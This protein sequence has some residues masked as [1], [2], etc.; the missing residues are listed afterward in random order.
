MTPEDVANAHEMTCALQEILDRYTPASTRFVSFDQGRGGSVSVFC[1]LQDGEVTHHVEV[2]ADTPIV[3]FYYYIGTT[4]VG[5]SLP[6]IPAALPP[7]YLYEK[8]LETALLCGATRIVIQ[9]QHGTVL[10]VGMRQSGTWVWE[11]Y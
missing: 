8:A 2:R 11:I 3:E 1:L 6:G 9:D 7:T 10:H 5:Q 4:Q